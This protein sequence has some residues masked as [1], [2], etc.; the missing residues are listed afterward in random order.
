ML[1]PIKGWAMEPGIG[2]VEEEEGEEESER[3]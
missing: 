1:S 2:G 3:M